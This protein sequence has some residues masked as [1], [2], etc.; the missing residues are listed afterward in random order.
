MAITYFLKDQKFL[1][2]ACNEVLPTAPHNQKILL[3][4]Q[5]ALFAGFQCSGFHMYFNF[6]FLF[7]IP[8]F[9]LYCFGVKEDISGSLMFN[10]PSL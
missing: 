5:K 9:S 8:I 10:C 1:Y 7:L 4:H 3:M 2:S 6:F